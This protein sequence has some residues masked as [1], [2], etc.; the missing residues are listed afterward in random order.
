MAGIEG[1]EE[2]VQGN[3]GASIP[4]SYSKESSI[5]EHMSSPSLASSSGMECKIRSLRMCSPSVF[6]RVMS[7]L[8][9]GGS[10]MQHEHSPVMS[11]T[12]PVPVPP[13]RLQPANAL[14]DPFEAFLMHEYVE[15]VAPM[16]NL[17]A[18]DS[19]FT[20]ILPWLALSERVLFDSIMGLSALNLHSKS[21]GTVSKDVAERYK[22]S[23]LKAIHENL[24][25]APYPRKLLYLCCSLLVLLYNI[26]ASDTGSVL[27]DL[28]IS[29][30]KVKELFHGRPQAPRDNPGVRD[31]F[32][33][34]VGLSFSIDMAI[35][36]RFNIC[37]SWEPD[38]LTAVYYNEN[39]PIEYTNEWWLQKSLLLLVRLSHFTHRSYVP[40]YQESLENYRLAEWQA[41]YNDLLEYG[42]LLPQALKPI[43]NVTSHPRTTFPRVYVFDEYAL[44]ANV[45]YHTGVIMALHLRPDQTAAQKAQVPLGAHDHAYQILGLLDT[46]DK[47]VFWI[48]IYWAHRAAAMCLMTQEERDDATDLT[49]QYEWQTGY[50]FGMHMALI[51]S[52]WNVI[53]AAGAGA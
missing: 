45:S 25:I 38:F 52:R 53:D 29:Y 13:P 17:Y 7:G 6:Q 41:I 9:G 14:S 35:S 26:V 51:E 20:Q 15:N 33:V 18:M 10:A 40:T 48:T 42:R 4:D 23:A 39:L 50:T 16:M 12:T 28:A 46:C 19:V 8:A 44:L 31:L 30:A 36:F 43:A 11:E 22:Q 49:R 27:S 3:G 24:E 32:I 5:D 1:P 2:G 34:C 37:C 21:P 47:P